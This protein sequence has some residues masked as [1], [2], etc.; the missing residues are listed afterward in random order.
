MGHTALPE[1]TGGY[2][3]RVQAQVLQLVNHHL[4]QVRPGHGIPSSSTENVENW[5]IEACRVSW[6]CPHLQEASP[7]TEMGLIWGIRYWYPQVSLEALNSLGDP[8]GEDDTIITHLNFPPS[9]VGEWGE[10]VPGVWK[11][12]ANTG[13]SKEQE[14]VEC[15]V[16]AL[17]GEGKGESSQHVSCYWVFLLDISSQVLGSASQGRNK[18][19]VLGGGRDIEVKEQLVIPPDG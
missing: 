16:W 2:H 8:E 3:L 12:I 11:D 1:A 14:I 19:K 5:L 17:W 9:Q 4:D 10:G 13:E 6:H 7:D 15:S 18:R